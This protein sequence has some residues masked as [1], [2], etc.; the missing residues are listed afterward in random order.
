[1]LARVRSRLY[2]V[3]LSEALGG[4]SG[5]EHMT[6]IISDIIE[7]RRI[8]P[9]TPV[10]TLLREVALPESYINAALTEHKV[11]GDIKDFCLTR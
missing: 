6:G 3:G 9:A 5:I 10:A 1:V 8:Q 2:L 11:I 4:M 7:Y